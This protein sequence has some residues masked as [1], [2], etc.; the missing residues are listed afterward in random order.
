MENPPPFPTFYAEDVKEPLPEDIYDKE[1][2]AFDEPTIIYEETEAERKAAL[3]AAKA[4]K[5]AKTAKIR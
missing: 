3:A 5:K 2:H 1:L 4:T